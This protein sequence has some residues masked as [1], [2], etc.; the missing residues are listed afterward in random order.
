M[1]KAFVCANVSLVSISCRGCLPVTSQFLSFITQSSFN[2]FWRNTNHLKGQLRRTHRVLPK[3]CSSS[4][5]NLIFILL[6]HFLGN[7]VFV[8]QTSVILVLDQWKLKNTRIFFNKPP[9]N[10]TIV[11]C[12]Q[13]ILPSQVCQYF[14]SHVHNICSQNSYNTKVQWF[15]WWAPPVLMPKTVALSQWM[16]LF[17]MLFLARVTFVILANM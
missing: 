10:K 11:L 15:A 4:N 8:A 9:H 5:V 6:P 3:H 17:E 16:L 12:F 13:Y 2:V 7:I 14:I 1:W